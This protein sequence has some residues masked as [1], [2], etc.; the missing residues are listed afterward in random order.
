MKVDLA[1]DKT[2]RGDKLNK[3][4]NHILGVGWLRV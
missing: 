4:P 1:G 2:A 3:M